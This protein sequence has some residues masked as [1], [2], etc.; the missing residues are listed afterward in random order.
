MSPNSPDQANVDAEQR[1]LDRLDQKEDRKIDVGQ[2]ERTPED[3]GQT[4]LEKTNDLQG[5]IRDLQR[6]ADVLRDKRDPGWQQLEN[7]CKQTEQG[8]LS[9]LKTIDGNN[10][11]DE[12]EAFAAKVLTLSTGLDATNTEVNTPREDVSEK[13]VPEPM[14]KTFETLLK[15][16]DDVGRAT[17]AEL[18][19]EAALH[20]D[21]GDIRLVQSRIEMFAAMPKELVAVLF[22]EQQVPSGKDVAYQ[23]ARGL[24]ESSPNAFL[25]SNPGPEDVVRSARE[26]GID[27]L[28]GVQTKLTD[29]KTRL[30]NEYEG[31]AA[32]TSESSKDDQI[33]RN[34]AII[35]RA[36]ENIR[37]L[38]TQL[39]GIGA[40][41]TVLD[42]AL[43]RMNVSVA[44]SSGRVVDANRTLMRVQE[45]YG[46]TLKT[47]DPSLAAEAEDAEKNTT[48]TPVEQAMNDQ[49]GR[50]I[51]VAVEEAKESAAAAD[52]VDQVQ[53]RTVARFG[54]VTSADNFFKGKTV[55]N[56]LNADA[57]TYFKRYSYV[58][59][60]DGTGNRKTIAVTAAAKQRIES[61]PRGA[62]PVL[63][64]AVESVTFRTEGGGRGGV[65]SYKYTGTNFENSVLDA[66]DIGTATNAGGALDAEGKPID[67]ANDPRGAIAR[68]QIGKQRSFRM[69]DY[70][71]K[72]AA[73]LKKPDGT[74]YD[75]RL[76][77]IRTAAGKTYEGV[78]ITTD[79]LAALER[80]APDGMTLVL[81]REPSN[82]VLGAPD[83][84]R[85]STGGRG[86]G[87]RAIR[88]VLMTDMITM[89]D[90]GYAK[91]NGDE[92]TTTSV[93][94]PTKTETA[95]VTELQR[96]REEDGRDI[97]RAMDQSEAIKSTTS[98]AGQ[99]GESL[100][101][102]QKL[103]TAGGE[104]TKRQA[105]VDFARA[106]AEPML[107]LLRDANTRRNVDVALGELRALK[108]ANLGVALGG[109]ERDIDARIKSLEDFSK[110]LQSDQ[111]ANIFET[112]M[113][114]SKFDADTWARWLS[115]ELPKILAAIAVATAV[116][117]TI[118][119]SCGTAAPLWAIA[120]GGAAGGL[121]GS[122][123]GAEAVH[124]G[125]HLLDS[126]VR[127]GRLAYSNRSRLFAY[128][129]G[130][131]V[132]DP[133]TG[134]KV[135][136]EFIKDVASPY[137]QE[138]A[139]SFVTTYAALGLGSIV[140][141]R[142][143]ALAQNSQWVQ[144]LATRSPMA[145]RV[146]T[147][148][149][150]VGDDA[151]R[152][153]AEKSS[154]I[155]TWFRESIDEL[156]DEFIR[157]KGV[158]AV[159]AQV[160]KRL[161][162]CAAFLVTVARGFK[163]MRVPN[164]GGNYLGSFTVEGVTD[165]PTLELAVQ[166]KGYPKVENAGNHLI[167]TD[168]DGK[169]FEV[170][171]DG[172]AVNVE[173]GTTP[174]V[175]STQSE[176]TGSLQRNKD[177][178][179]N[180]S[181]GDQ[182][183][184]SRDQIVDD[185]AAQL[186]Q[187]NG[188]RG[189][190]VKEEI[191]SG[192]QA[193][194]SGVSVLQETDL[195]QNTTMFPLPVVDGPEVVVRVSKDASEATRI[196][197][198]GKILHDR[199]TERAIRIGRKTAS[200]L[201]EGTTVGD[202]ARQIAETIAHDIAVNSDA[203]TFVLEDAYKATGSWDAAIEQAI[204]QTPLPSPDVVSTTQDGGTVME[205][206][207]GVTADSITQGDDLSPSE[208][209][210]LIF[211][212][213]LSV[214]TIHDAGVVHRDLKPQNMIIGGNGSVRVVDLGLST[215]TGE[216]A[217]AGGSLKT[218]APEQSRKGLPATP[219]SDVFSLGCMTFQ[220][221][222]RSRR[223]PIDLINPEAQSLDDIPSS[224]EMADVKGLVETE[225][226]NCDP[227]M[228]AMVNQMLSIDPASRP[229]MNEVTEFFRSRTESHYKQDRA[230]IGQKVNQSTAR[231][232]YDTDT[233]RLPA[234]KPETAG[235]SASA[236]SEV[237]VDR[238]RGLIAEAQGSKEGRAKLLDYMKGTEIDDATRIEIAEAL[239]GPMTQAQQDALI[240]AHETGN[241]NLV[242]GYSADELQAKYNAL[243]ESGL[244]KAQIGLLMDTG[245]AGNGIQGYPGLDLSQD[246]IVLADD[247]GGR[248]RERW[249]Q[250][251]ANRNGP[252]RDPVITVPETGEH[253][254][255]MPGKEARVQRTGGGVEGGWKITSREQFVVM[256]NPAGRRTYICS[257]ADTTKIRSWERMGY[258][259]KRIEPGC[260]VEN[261]LGS[262]KEYLLSELAKLNEVSTPES[263]PF[264][265]GTPITLNK[266][267]GG[268]DSTPMTGRLLSPITV[269]EAI[270]V[271][272]GDQSRRTT[273]IAKIFPP[274]ASGYHVVLTESGSR[275][276]VMVNQAQVQKPNPNNDQKASPNRNDQRFI[277]LDDV[278]QNPHLNVGYTVNVRLQS[279]RVESGC[280]VLA[281]EQVY[282]MRNPK[283][284][285]ARL[286]IPASEVGAIEANKA[287]GFTIETKEPGLIVLDGNSTRRIC[288]LRELAFV[289]QQNGVQRSQPDAG[290]E[291]LRD[292]GAFPHLRPGEEIQ[293]PGGRMR[294]THRI[295]SREMVSTLRNDAGK[296]I[297]I[298]SA[299]LASRKIYEAQGYRLTTVEPGIVVDTDAGT[300]L[301]PLSKIAELNPLSMSVPR[302]LDRGQLPQF[303]EG[304]LVAVKNDQGLP[305]RGWRITARQEM[306]RMQ[307]NGSTRF[308]S[309][310][311][312][313]E[314]R[315]NGWE[316][317]ETVILCTVEKPGKPA[318]Q[319]RLFELY[320]AN[321]AGEMITPD[322]GKY[323]HLRPGAR[324]K[325][326][327]PNGRTDQQCTIKDRR[328]V[329][330]IQDANGD[331]LRLGSENTDAIGQYVESGW[332][333]V[334]SETVCVVFDSIG[335]EHTVS[336]NELARLNAERIGDFTPAALVSV[337]MANGMPDPGWKIV[338]QNNDG[339]IKVKKYNEQTGKWMEQA[340]S[341]ETLKA[342]NFTAPEFAAEG[343]QPFRVD[344][345]VYVVRRS[346]GAPER[347]WRVKRTTDGRWFV[348]KAAPTMS[349]EQ[350]TAFS[351]DPNKVAHINEVEGTTEEMATMPRDKAFEFVR[352]MRQHLER[353]ATISPVEFKLLFNGE[354]MQQNVGNCYLIASFNS[355]KASP[356]FEAIIRTSV[357]VTKDGYYVKFPLGGKEPRTRIFVSHADLEKQKVN[358]SEDEY[359]R[360]SLHPVQG[361][362]GWQV[363]EAAYVKLHTG[364]AMNRAE[365]EGGY[366]HRALGEM[367]GTGVEQ[368]T[369]EGNFSSSLEASGKKADVVAWLNRFHNGRDIGTVNT[370][371]RRERRGERSDS[372][373]YDAQASGRP[374]K[375]FYSHAYS[376]ESVQKFNSPPIV[377]VKNPHDTS[378]PLVFTFDEFVK[379]FADTSSV[380]LN[381]ENMFLT[382]R[383]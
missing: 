249:G 123:L 304:K 122:Q 109:V 260:V 351:L 257:A 298:R 46:E 30:E 208:R 19:A 261:S 205:R 290:P 222:S 188:G 328:Q 194:V 213:A 151:A 77:T 117:V 38:E 15:P 309:T 232:S 84:E 89:A 58:S 362:T 369:I 80:P 332:K 378:Q 128:L 201:P 29:A 320:E 74:P 40:R 236:E 34:V 331:I 269:G 87:S 233:T 5:K 254:H 63:L 374:V 226:S 159:L 118:I 64:K 346:S 225:M 330:T 144:G 294:E 216:T 293:I 154:F 75:K 265:S 185:E 136:L 381:F 133:V 132:I 9:T 341:E 333:I 18:A 356:H 2:S 199:I 214:Q 88:R 35:Q 195:S 313:D 319:V 175:A 36:Q 276:S 44:R 204:H 140:A 200:E 267:G 383:S 170:H 59:V 85:T 357:E 227:E 145:N 238:V 137:A 148:L 181:P 92:L 302:Q 212:Y 230:R 57:T 168:H 364:G 377:R 10:V 286:I 22:P 310:L 163:P 353:N 71:V 367:F 99:I 347:G 300:S 307:R 169:T 25:L 41:V 299:D 380:S 177:G 350:M 296:T 27:E 17:C 305:D 86:G 355:L 274:N 53:A 82:I 16:T 172:A 156:Q 138:F 94:D 81:K 361:S 21:A 340:V 56:S 179:S 131:E 243:A 142:L 206:V 157:E 96:E 47:L 198:V 248:V 348:E 291:I 183:R 124:L 202:G 119:A 61:F 141:S 234:K 196:A 344:E 203:L 50:S 178:E 26:A 111:V 28:N 289:N 52:I 245:V 12:A 166:S 321:V 279:G 334:S 155:K 65:M 171:L 231:N 345:E 282:V 113:D 275:Y 67:M 126:D 288:T 366:G 317:Q 314:L 139:F 311:E 370:I 110:M 134:K 54:A 153:G 252:T 158:E 24:L 39:Q 306:C 210:S 292:S 4:Y 78:T 130:Q 135:P 283:D 268:I 150:Q 371:R 270:V 193:S 83:T 37:E 176:G 209:E 301:F 221:L 285:S 187:S 360:T 102:L 173:A 73:A 8:L 66:K 48:L 316:I 105:M 14:Q 190:V 373:T 91:I 70:A 354:L 303:S 312:A 11:V 120:A 174:E 336:L 363:L 250:R 115:T 218:A 266:L 90:L 224:Y 247:H 207:A 326:A 191:G 271:V 100:T 273:R 42:L 228:R 162:P 255:L 263:L 147:Y 62:K 359:N 76:L 262:K 379:A 256:E 246:D 272:E 325:L 253:P 327:L 251:E 318:K 339:S 143:S 20:Y 295:A 93:T 242:D 60:F 101:H 121:I 192:G 372:G 45:Q 95:S 338:S 284:P 3:L 342:Q 264:V 160:D 72:P 349:G 103:L 31:L 164:T 114:K 241:G 197:E 329:T 1:R 33:A 237:D 278:G 79:A 229:T 51:D 322:N 315:Q 127:S 240:R 352:R 165:M 211:G 324:V 182:N 13:P 129:E 244:S 161:G 106:E 107:R 219:A 375:L 112:I 116:I 217:M 68:E 55:R 223:F 69:E 358:R 280:K 259:V 97:L 323:G 98:A 235:P 186:Q 125:R 32:R 23:L 382:S 184:R 376:I 104:G 287:L 180:P 277:T 281:R 49:G 368:G 189:E 7:A 308:V 335:S 152:V 297:L 146:M 6:Q 343:R 258:E 239:I 365:V 220:L 167:V 149:S 43:V 215:E 337:P 108:E